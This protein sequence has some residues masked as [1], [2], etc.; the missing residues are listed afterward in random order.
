LVDLGWILRGSWRVLRG[1]WLDLGWT[2]V[3]LGRSSVDLLFLG[4]L[5]VDRSVGLWVAWSNMAPR[6]PKMLQDGPRWLQD[7]VF[8]AYCPSRSKLGHAL[9]VHR[10]TLFC[11]L[12]KL[13]KTN[14]FENIC[15]FKIWK[16]A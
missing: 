15:F 11:M 2:L 8:A 3:D 5:W 9:F 14:V 7:V 12:A 10:H 4:D 1:S 6:W 16:Q 13:E